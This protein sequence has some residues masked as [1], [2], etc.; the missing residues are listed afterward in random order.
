MRNKFA[1]ATFHLWQNGTIV[2]HIV[3]AKWRECQYGFWVKVFNACNEKL[4]FCKSEFRIESVIQGTVYSDITRV[5]LQG[6]ASLQ[7]NL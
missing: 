4:H 6:E 1:V 2:V 3:S 7:I 5:K